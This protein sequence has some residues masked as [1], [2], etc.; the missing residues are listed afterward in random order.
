MTRLNI[1]GAR[2][3][4]MESR[5]RK[6]SL[7][8]LHIVENSE[9]FQNSCTYSFGD[10]EQNQRLKKLRCGI[11]LYLMHNYKYLA[12][13]Y[14]CDVIDIYHVFLTLNAGY[15]AYSIINSATATNHHF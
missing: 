8:K 14:A 4:E 13:I 6:H 10:G 3:Y 9:I 1:R 2:Y 12:T 5:K 15:P 11:I 7:S